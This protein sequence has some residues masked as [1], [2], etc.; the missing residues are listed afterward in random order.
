[1]NRSE[2]VNGTPGLAYTNS[3]PDQHSI[4]PGGQHTLVFYTKCVMPEGHVAVVVVV[5]VVV[6]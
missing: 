2:G 1:M 6:V 5:V 4:Y 3:V